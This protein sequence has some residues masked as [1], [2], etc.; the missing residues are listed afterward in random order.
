[1]SS[2]RYDGLYILEGHQKDAK[3][4][5]IKASLDLIE[6][7]INALGGTVTGTQKMDRRRFERVADDKVDSGFY[8]NVQFTLAPGKLA[9]LQAK[10]K[11]AK[12]IFRQFY[13]KAKAEKAAA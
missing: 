4:D 5:P 2:N 10:L 11:L 1:M 6:K 8:A 3:D 13:L 7:E 9:N 12:G